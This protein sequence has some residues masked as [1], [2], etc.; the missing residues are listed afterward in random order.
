LDVPDFVGV[1]RNYA[2]LKQPKLV[3]MKEFGAVSSQFHIYNNTFAART[4][5]NDGIGRRPN[6][7]QTTCCSSRVITDD[8][9]N[10]DS[11]TKKLEQ[12]ISPN[13]YS[14]NVLNDIRCASG[15]VERCKDRVTVSEE[16]RDPVRCSD[17][18]HTQGD[19]GPPLPLPPLLTRRFLFSTIDTRAGGITFLAKF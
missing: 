6:Q 9:C 13:N 10:D 19:R 8:A 17:T 14:S 5:E 1:V 16:M 12:H 18:A 2:K 4:D 15:K 11:N 3:Q 7:I